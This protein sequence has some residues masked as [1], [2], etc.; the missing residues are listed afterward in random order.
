MKCAAQPIIA[1]VL[2]DMASILGMFI[3]GI[4]IR[5]AIEANRVIAAVPSNPA[6]MDFKIDVL[7]ILFCSFLVYLNCTTGTNIKCCVSPV[8]REDDKCSF[9]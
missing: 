5:G 2:I 8:C 6:M 9:L 1:G 4:P 7:Y 3:S